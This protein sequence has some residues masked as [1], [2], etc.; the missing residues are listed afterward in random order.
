MKRTILRS[1]ITKILDTSTLAERSRTAG[2][3]EFELERYEEDYAR[4]VF[5]TSNT[6]VL[7]SKLPGYLQI[8]WTEFEGDLIKFIE[9]E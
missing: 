5:E 4:Q 3:T 2:D 9:E 7:L 1:A 6:S 8:K